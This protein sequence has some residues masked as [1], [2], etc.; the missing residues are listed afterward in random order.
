MSCPADVSG[1]GLAWERS[2]VGV[3]AQFVGAPHCSR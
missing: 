1:D 3:V 2:V